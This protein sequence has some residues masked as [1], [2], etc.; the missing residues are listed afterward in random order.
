MSKLLDRAKEIAREAHGGQFTKIGEPFIEHVTRVADAV[1]NEDEKIVAWLH[2]V[3][4]KSSTWTLTALRQ[5]A[6]PDRIVAAVDA[7][8]KREDEEY[9][10][11]VQ[12][13]ARD[14]L[15]RGV[16]RADLADN[17]DQIKQIDGDTSKYA[18]G[19]EL[20]ETQFPS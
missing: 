1:T 11:F 2:D 8:T 12:R 5:Q 10:A 4:E 3:V 13:S 15:A 18:S 9:L 7:M 20:I 17:L 19:L 14:P 16:K 6:F